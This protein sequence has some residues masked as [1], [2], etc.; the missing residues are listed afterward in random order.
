M[1]KVSTLDMSY[2]QIKIVEKAV[3][4][5]VQRWGS[6]PDVSVLD[7]YCHILAATSGEPYESFAAWSGQKILDAVSL[8]EADDPNP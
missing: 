6:D 7:I 2:A 8:D 5:P 1:A 4:I 3:G